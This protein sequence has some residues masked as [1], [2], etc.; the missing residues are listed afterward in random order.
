[1]MST[2]ALVVSGG[3]K[4]DLIARDDDS[5]T[6]AQ[7]GF[8]RYKDSDGAKIDKLGLVTFAD[9]GSQNA[10]LLNRLSITYGTNSV[11]ASNAELVSVTRTG[12]VGVGTS[13]PKAEMHLST[14]LFVASKAT[15]ISSN[16]ETGR[17]CTC[18]TRAPKIRRTSSLPTNAV[19]ERK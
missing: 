19:G 8:G 13:A 16:T 3:G 1:M 18:G 9:T 5:S 7:I 14:E 17:A 2:D 12:R 11:P 15:S 10:N 4:L 6:A